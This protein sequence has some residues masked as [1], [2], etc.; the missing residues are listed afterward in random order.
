[1]VTELYL[2]LA[3]LVAALYGRSVA[4]LYRIYTK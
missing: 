4:Q 2:A 1:M 3:L